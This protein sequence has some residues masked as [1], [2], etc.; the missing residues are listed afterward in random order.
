M[1]AAVI[2]AGGFIGGHLCR[3]LENAG[4]QV[5]ALD[6][7]RPETPVAGEFRE[8]DI[9]AGPPSFEDNTEAVFYLA[10]SPF[11][12]EFP[13]RAD[14][15][16]GVNALGPV[17]AASAALNK[18]CR[19][20][21]FASTGNVYAPSFD[22]LPESHPVRRD[23]PYALSKVAAEE[24]LDLFRGRMG[25]ISTRIFGAF[26]PGQKSMLPVILAGRIKSGTPITLQ[27]APGET[28]E[29]GGLR[30]SYLYVEDMARAMIRLADKALDGGE[31]PPRLNLAGPEALSIRRFATAI[32][33]AMGMEPVFETAETPRGLDLAADVSLMQQVLGLA[34]TP[35]EE[36]AAAAFGD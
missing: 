19:F 4:H 7:V 27:P 6:A 15:L 29:T 26:G 16:F 12:R 18:G 3:L 9:L 13:N 30:V 11:Y 36:A 21:L 34:F 31:L 2:G 33:G 32:G 17:R 1:K 23:D 22:A 8:C 5:L 10:Q 20:F 25:V 28:V 35:L 14:H 24:A